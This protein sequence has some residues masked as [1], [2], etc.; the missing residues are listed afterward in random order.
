M[1]LNI[2]QVSTDSFFWNDINILAKEAFPPEEYLSPNKL[3]EMAKDDNFDFFA[4]V[5][6][7]K[8]IGF[9]VVQTYKDIAYLF[10]LAICSEYRSKGYG[11]KAIETL[12]EIYKNKKQVVDLEM[13]DKHAGNSKQREKRK[14]F[15]IRNGYKETGLFLSYLGVDYEVL[16]MDDEFEPEIFKEMM[17]NLKIE[18]LNPKYFYKK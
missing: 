13:L 12:K 4:L 14:I 5:E 16:C 2:E 11:S 18:G 3:V 7:K 8:F 1:I 17:S 10:F 6:E 15:Y 9:M